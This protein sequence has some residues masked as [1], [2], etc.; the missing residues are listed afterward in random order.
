MI[1]DVQ[2]LGREWLKKVQLS[3]W[4]E[5][6]K[7]AKTGATYAP[8]N[9]LEH[10][11]VYSDTPRYMLLKGGEGAGKSVAGIIKTLNRLRRGMSGIMVAPDFEHFKKSLWPEFKLWCPWQ[12]VIDSQQRRQSEAWEPSGHFTLVI[13][14]ELGGYSELSCGGAKESEIDSWRGPNKSFVLMDEASR[15]REPKAL[16][17]FDGRVRIPGPANEPGQIF[18]TT[19]PE[20]HWLYDYFGPL[21]DGDELANFKQDSFVATVR[22]KEN[23]AN[24]EDGYVEKRAQSL[25][26][27]E[28]RVFLDAE[29][30][31]ISD[32]EKFVNLVWWENCYEPLPAVTR[33]EPMVIALDAAKG[34]TGSTLADCFAVVGVTRHPSRPKDVAIRYCGIWQPTQG[35]LLDYEPIENRFTILYKQMKAKN[36]TH[37]CCTAIRKGDI[38]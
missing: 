25:N 29:W 7:N 24:L 37:A 31:R 2:E 23:E 33:S 34:S 27:A 35:Q 12:V 13:K 8:H 9:E 1:I 18:F 4:P 19:T 10:K 22:A 28:V 36:R 30:E 11:F 26:A 38:E 14:N 32:V 15:H 16:K 21:K 17:V 3:K 6:Y 5:Q 20:M